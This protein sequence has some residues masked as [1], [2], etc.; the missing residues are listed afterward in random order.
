MEKEVIDEHLR[1][2]W[3][4]RDNPAGFG[5]KQ[6]LFKAA[7][8]ELKELSVEQVDEWLRGQDVYT[9]FQG[10]NRPIISRKYFSPG[11]FTMLEADLMF[12]PGETSNFGYV[13]ALTVVD[14][15]SRFAFVKPIKKKSAQSVAAK[16]EEIFDDPRVISKIQ[17]LRTDRGREF[18]NAV[19]GKVCNQRGILQFFANPNNKTKCAIV[20]RF[21]RT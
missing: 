13:G 2:I 20:E 4:S 8:K 6:K 19:V 18:D 10:R 11:A 9:L 5:G 17:S 12:L 16:L 7:K 21:N 14:V 3:Y 15:F 1:R